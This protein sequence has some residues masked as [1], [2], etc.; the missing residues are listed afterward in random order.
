MTQSRPIH[1][2][3]AEHQALGAAGWTLED[4]MRK[5]HDWAEVFRFHFKLEIPR[6]PLRL[7]R[8]RRNCLGHYNPGFND[9]GLTDEIAIDVAHLVRGITSGAWYDVLGTLLHE[10][11]HFDQQLRGTAPTPGPGNY[12][13][14]EYRGKAEQLGLLVSSRGVGEGYVPG[15][16]FLTL[17]A[18]RGEAMPDLRFPVRA[19]KPAGNSPLKKWSCGCT[20]VRVAVADFH[21][22]CLRCCNLFERIGAG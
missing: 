17:L 5:L 20:N 15:G 4:A 21:A 14:V 16:P 9:F 6:V 8:L 3:L 22:R 10:Q 7:A 13:N 18:E 19:P 12:H 2:A 11:L 1:E